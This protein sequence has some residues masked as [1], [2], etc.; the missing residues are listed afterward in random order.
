MCLVLAGSLAGCAGT[1]PSTYDPNE[2]QGIINILHTVEK[3]D[4]KDT[5]YA[6]YSSG[7]IKE[8]IQWL[9][10]Y[11]EMKGNEDI[12]LSIHTIKVTASGLKKGMSTGFCRIKKQLLITQIE[13]TA[14]AIM[15][16]YGE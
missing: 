16:R 13:S 3:L 5:E 8:M 12:L 7:E 11:S 2:S 9:H 6:E 15:S 1:I 10:L 4:C 14:Q